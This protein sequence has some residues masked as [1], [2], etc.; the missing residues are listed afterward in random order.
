VSTPRTLRL[1]DCA[2]PVR[3]ATA[4]GERAALVATP[5][6]GVE[7]A[8]TAI[9]VP[10]FTGSKEDFIDVLEP[11]AA[12]GYEVVAY[13]QRGQFES[14]DD[15]GDGEPLSAAT[16]V[17]QLAS[18]VVAVADTV[19][20]E[21]PVHVVGHSMGG[22]VARGVALARPDRVASL[23]LLC[24]GPSALPAAQQ[25]ALQT[26]VAALDDHSLEQVWQAKAQL[27][28]ANGVAEPP[29][30]VQ[31]FLHRRFVANSPAAL[32][33][34][35]TMLMEE[36]DRVDALAAV[37][38]ARGLPALV[39]V[40]EDDDAWPV[41]CQADMARRLGAGLVVIPGA[42]HS[43]AV[44]QPLATAEALLALWAPRGQ[45]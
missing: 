15:S 24:S 38:G 22:L 45:V 18:D 36:P 14:P 32:V 10:G 26:L 43:P 40:G 20:A 11:L 16:V 8:G 7:P 42:G 4:R 13:D 27:D 25:G 12:A 34:K 39:L 29:A 41:D 35:A 19:A 5:A 1:P 37:L 44:D 31:D 2:R 17:E 23:T 3:L 28:R 30:E 6:G 9:L 33:A 21:S